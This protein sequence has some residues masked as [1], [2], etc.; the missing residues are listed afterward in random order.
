MKIDWFEERLWKDTTSGEEF[1]KKSDR[2]EHLHI[3]IVQTDLNKHSSCLTIDP[4][5]LVKLRKIA[6]KIRQTTSKFVH[7]STTSVC[8]MIARVAIG[9]EL[10]ARLVFKRSTNR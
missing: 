4:L 8:G 10:I 9:V 2:S 1:N 5:Q 3:W 7:I 6:L